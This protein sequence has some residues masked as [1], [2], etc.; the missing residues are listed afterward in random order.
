MDFI[1]IEGY[2]LKN[3]R[4]WVLKMLAKRI[5]KNPI[6]ELSYHQVLDRLCRIAGFANWNQYSAYW[7]EQEYETSTHVPF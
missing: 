7:K 6:Y 3:A 5:K 2:D 4:P 1:E